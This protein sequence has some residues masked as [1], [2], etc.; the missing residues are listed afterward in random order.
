M[1]P[2]GP[3][4]SGPAGDRVWLTG[5]NLTGGRVFFGDVPGINSSCGPSFCTV[6]SPPGT[7]TVD[8]RVATFGGISPVTSWDKYTYTG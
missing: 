4:G 6:T 1:N 2:G 3:L 5:N 7:G 8:V